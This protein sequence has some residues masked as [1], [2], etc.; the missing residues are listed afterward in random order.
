M[1]GIGRESDR[2]AE[3]KGSDPFFN[4]MARMFEMWEWQYGEYKAG[5]LEIEQ[6]PI[7]NWRRQY[8]GEDSTPNPFR[9]Y[10]KSLR[11]LLSPDFVELMEEN[12]TN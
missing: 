4:M 8:H 11:G 1:P 5:M 12:V 2:F 7:A 9:Y 10:W 6:L 3:P